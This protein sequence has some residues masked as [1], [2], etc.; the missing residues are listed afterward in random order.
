[1]RLVDGGA[2]TNGTWEYGR[3]EVGVKGIWSIVEDSRFD[4]DLGRRGALV[5]CRTLGFD[6]GAQLLAGRSSPFPAP[7]FAP[8]LIQDIICDGSEDTLA[9]CDILRKPPPAFDQNDDY[10]PEVVPGSVALLCTSLSGVF[11]FP[12]FPSKA[13]CRFHASTAPEQAIA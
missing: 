5:A 7:Y 12:L 8:S 3:M 10:S 2:D 11:R 9:D 13:F 6:T 4:Q 1:M